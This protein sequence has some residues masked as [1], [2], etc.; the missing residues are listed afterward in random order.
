M[1]RIVLVLL[2]LSG[3][4]IGSPG[5]DGMLWGL[6][7]ALDISQYNLDV[8][9]TEDGL[10][11]SSV[12]CLLQ[13]SDGY[14][15]L[16]TYEGFARFDGVRFTV[17]DTA[18]TAEMMGNRV[19]TLLEDKQKALWIGTSGGLLQYYKG[20]FNNFTTAEGL[21]DDFI[22]CLFEDHLN[23][24]WIGTTHG[25]NL[26]SE[27]RFS[28]YAIDEIS[29]SRHYISALAEDKQHNLWVG[30]SGNGLFTFKDN[31][32]VRPHIGSLPGDLDVRALYVDD[33]GDV[34]IGTSGDGI[35]VVKGDSFRVYS[36]TDGLSGKD[37]RALSQDAHGCLWIGTN[38]S[39]LNRFK[40]GE[41]SFLSSEQGFF[42]SPIRA[43]LED[44][45]G[46]IWI[47]TRD[48]L[49]KLTQGKFII[50]NR[51]NGL[52]VDIARTMVQDTNGTIWIGTV[53]GGLV[54]Y[55]EH[56]FITVGED[57]GL[58]NSHIW[59]L[60]AGSDNDL[61]AG[62]YGGGLFHLVNGKVVK[63]YTTDN[64]LSDNVVRAV[65]ADGS[66]RIWVGT[67][68][69][70][71]DQL[72]P[73]N[74]AITNYNNENGLSDNFVYAI[75]HDQQ[76]SIWVGTFYGNLNRI[77]EGNIKVYDRS[78]GFGG[79]AIWSVYPDSGQPGVIWLGT[80]GGGLIRF[81]PEAGRFDRFTVRDGLFSDQAFE[82]LDDLDGKLWLN[83]NKGI[84][85]VEK[86]VLDDYIAKKI[87]RIPTTAFGGGGGNRHIESTGPAQPA[88]MRAADGSLWFPTIR[89]AV[90]ITP[91]RIKT[92][93]V[94]P[95]VVIEEIHLNG[96]TVYAYPSPVP[97][98][99][100][101]PA[102]KNRLEI[103]FTGLS[104]VVPQRVRFKCKLEHYDK[105]WLDVRG[106]RHVSYTNLE[107]GTYH[108]HVKACNNDGVWN[109][110][111]ASLT[112]TKRG[113]IYQST[114][115]QLLALAI[116][117]A[118][119]YLL[120]GF[121]RSHL[122]LIAFWERKKII[123]SYEIDDMIGAGGMGMVY[124]VHS[125][126]DRSKTFA[127]K[128]M[129]EEFLDDE[130][131]Q[132]RFKNEA[133]MVDRIDHPN[134]VK[135]HE[136]GEHEGNLYIVMELLDGL[137]LA[138]RFDAGEYPEVDQ[139]IRIMSQVAHILVLLH[140]EDIIHRDL[141]PENIMLVE[142]DG[143][144]DHVKL[145]DFGIARGQH[146]PQLTETG[147]VLGTISYMPPEVVHK[148]E[149]SPAVDVYSLGIIGYEMLTRRRPFI[150]DQLMDTM[151]D[152]MVKIPRE[153]IEINPKM[154][155]RLN[156]L[157]MEMIAKDPVQRPD[158]RAVLAV[159]A[160]L[161]KLKKSRNGETKPI[162]HL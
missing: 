156:Q 132:R 36:T 155:P 126:M 100:H 91:G 35:Y 79:H 6:D 133:M 4:W 17:F 45:E 113:Y 64:G 20:A 34:W 101:L 56:R 127:M 98:T 62:T 31:K 135:V 148:G 145:L 121:V 140:R 16:G 157:V 152:I 18:N 21:S 28:S 43:I 38:G 147:Q 47:G 67:N 84:F 14:I 30:T 139:C 161:M 162:R 107:P 9:T 48:G 85:N 11:Q 61:W 1:R 49:S 71:I 104:F 78:K 123:G 115:F 3:L 59:T 141:K 23:R 15:W 116:F 96:E 108:F 109:E 93:P 120:I 39:G 55:K 149:F 51:R 94:E 25:L 125:L 72:N 142:H 33:S 8:Y 106:G 76:G 119:S 118:F 63:Q 131:Q 60:A 86:K 70:G 37:I 159:L 40:K 81:R 117:A 77:Q 26:Y 138:E 68:G 44:R 74:G 92:N 22:V 102:G 128:V 2:L 103:T 90:V 111:G 19:R 27:K 42:S 57:Q 83:G 144:K 10:P 95:L 87:P 66:G 32:L 12:L 88:S 137:T 13:T 151:K 122:K 80:D 7:P 160:S 65:H 105:N 129:K 136:R 82:V 130:I 143:D 5:N 124:K 153:P 75:A 50:Y 69:G 99:I 110:T 89:G 54:Q 52:P 41:F 150:G 58:T 24:L 53:G 97:Q 114:L 154:P 112:I 46:S 146:M 73:L 158:A 134:I 29:E